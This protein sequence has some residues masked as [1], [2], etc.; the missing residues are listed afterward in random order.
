MYRKRKYLMV[1]EEYDEEEGG[2][3]TSEEKLGFYDE[4]QGGL[5]TSEE[6]LGFYD[7]EQGGLGTSE[8]QMRFI[9]PPHPL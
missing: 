4:E 7:E 8:E 2:L 5:G 3:G 6:K 1:K 9:P